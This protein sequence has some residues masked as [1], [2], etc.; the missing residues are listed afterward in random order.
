MAPKTSP[1][2]VVKLVNI[3]KEKIILLVQKRPGPEKKKAFRQ[4]IFKLCVGQ[5]SKGMNIPR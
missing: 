5:N 4:A 2:K 3:K 1:T